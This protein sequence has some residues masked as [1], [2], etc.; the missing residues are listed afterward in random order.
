MNILALSTHLVVYDLEMCATCV[1]FPDIPSYLIS[2][3]D[4]TA[5]CEIALYFRAYFLSTL[6]YS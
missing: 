1:P 3:A 6:C 5:Q 4:Q 2:G